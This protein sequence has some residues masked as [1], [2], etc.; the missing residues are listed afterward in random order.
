MDESDE[1]KDQTLTSGDDGDEKEDRG[2]E[3][4]EEERVHRPNC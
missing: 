2:R 4:G 1:V 3:K